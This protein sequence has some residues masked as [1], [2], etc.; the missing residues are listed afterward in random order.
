[1]G[2]GGVAAD[3]PLMR[4]DFESDGWCFLRGLAEKAEERPNMS[5][6]SIGRVSRSESASK[7][8]LW[9]TKDFLRKGDDVRDW[10]LYFRIER[11]AMMRDGR[12]EW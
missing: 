2:V 11:G 6:A 12:R 9:G 5:S 4:D 7:S 8:E 10:A 1:M 3:L